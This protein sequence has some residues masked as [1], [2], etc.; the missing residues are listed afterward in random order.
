M[1]WRTFTAWILFSS[2]ALWVAAASDPEIPPVNVT[3]TTAR[4]G[5]IIKPFMRFADESQLSDPR[6][7]VALVIGVGACLFTYQ[8]M[9][10]SLRK[11]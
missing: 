10:Q 11:S 9:W 4:P 2:C 3:A 5:M 8:R 1:T 6:Q 7:V